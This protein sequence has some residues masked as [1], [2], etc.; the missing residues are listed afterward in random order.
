MSTDYQLTLYPGAITQT[1]N[2]Y[3]G[4]M[5]DS[6]NWFPQNPLHTAAGGWVEG[7]TLTVLCTVNTNP[8]GVTPPPPLSQY[9]DLRVGACDAQDPTTVSQIEA[10][11]TAYSTTKLI[12]GNIT[13]ESTGDNYIF[14]NATSTSHP[15]NFGARGSKNLINKWTM[16][17][18][19]TNTVRSD[20]KHIEV[21]FGWGDPQEADSDT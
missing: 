8:R 20:G 11:I 15:I 14:V 2:C 1:G 4:S 13:T 18:N 21:I 9:V 5:H 10:G 16:D 3:S 19:P 6:V 12:W 17:Y 7:D